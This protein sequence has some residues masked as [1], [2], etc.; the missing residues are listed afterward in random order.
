MQDVYQLLHSLKQWHH[1]NENKILC[2]VETYSHIHGCCFGSNSVHKSVRRCKIFVSGFGI[3]RTDLIW[4]VSFVL[5]Y[6]TP[7]WVVEPLW[8][9]CCIDGYKIN[10]SCGKLCGAV[11]KPSVGQ[12][13]VA[14][15]GTWFMGRENISFTMDWLYVTYP[16]ITPRCLVLVSSGIMGIT[17][18][19]A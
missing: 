8:D 13:A 5:C 6:R 11:T 10:C 2:S 17:L 4:R 19:Q 12:L 1:L 16:V 18:D 14:C 3:S 7:C 15:C 9:F